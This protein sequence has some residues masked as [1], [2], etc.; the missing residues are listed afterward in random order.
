MCLS[1]WVAA[2]ARPEPLL[3]MKNVP[4]GMCCLQEATKATTNSEG[5]QLDLKCDTHL[6]VFGD[7]PA[8]T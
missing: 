4:A 7:D 6:P 1:T 2:P 3:P 5:I 8:D